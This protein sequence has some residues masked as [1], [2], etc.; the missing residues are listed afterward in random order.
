M[1]DAA[2]AA[3]TW[4]VAVW[5]TGRSSRNKLQGHSTTTSMFNVSSQPSQIS[6][7]PIHSFDILAIYLSEDEAFHPSVY[8]LFI[9]F[10]LL[11][12]TFN[13]SLAFPPNTFELIYLPNAPTQTCPCISVFP[14]TFFPFC[15]RLG[16]HQP[17]RVYQSPVIAYPIVLNICAP[18]STPAKQSTSPNHS[19]PFLMAQISHMLISHMLSDDTT[20]PHCETIPFQLPIINNS[21]HDAPLMRAQRRAGRQPHTN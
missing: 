2:R 6:R 15:D 11:P 14:Q 5:V 4:Y 17:L 20:L 18:Y 21:N 16:P 3:T 7:G 10:I 13:F 1:I 9:A 12:S 19:D 8:H